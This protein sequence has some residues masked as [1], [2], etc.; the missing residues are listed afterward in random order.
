MT[1]SIENVSAAQHDRP[2][3]I[4]FE[5]TTDVDTAVDLWLRGAGHDICDKLGVSVSLLSRFRNELTSAELADVRRTIVE[6]GL[7]VFDAMAHPRDI[8]G[9]EIEEPDF[10]LR[11]TLL[12]ANAY[13]ASQDPTLGELVAT[14]I[15]KLPPKV[16]DSLAEVLRIAQEQGVAFED[17][18]IIKEGAIA[19]A[20][21]TVPTDLP[22]YTDEA[23][24]KFLEDERHKKRHPHQG[25]PEATG[26]AIGQRQRNA[27]ARAVLRPFKRPKAAR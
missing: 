14:A 27:L 10:N 16:A 7:A 4:D 20:A 6:Q 2:L 25:D 26:V 3:Q 19:N 22:L 12:L 15:S 23:Y 1:T 24:R 18:R 17:A 21:D 11:S 13:D 9:N 8:E 5:A